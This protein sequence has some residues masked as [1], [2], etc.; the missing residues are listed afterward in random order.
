MKTYSK[1][2][3]WHVFHEAWTRKFVN[4]PK[5]NDQWERKKYVNV[6]L[7]L[8]NEIAKINK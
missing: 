8:A 2:Y 6:F 4:L 3:I 1:T 7:D 5:D